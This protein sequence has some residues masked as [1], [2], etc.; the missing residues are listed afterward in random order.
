MISISNNYIMKL[1]EFSYS[2][3]KHFILSIRINNHTN[4]YLVKFLEF[5]CYKSIQNI[6]YSPI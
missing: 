2:K 5:S 1:V 4:G 3:M 6:K